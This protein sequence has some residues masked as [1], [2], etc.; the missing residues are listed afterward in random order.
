[1]YNDNRGMKIIIGL[2]V[3]AGILFGL[4]ELGI[5]GKSD[6]DKIRERMDKFVTAYNNG[7]YEGMLECIEPVKRK[8]YE[9]A[10][11]MLGSIGSGL[12]GFD[13]SVSDLMGLSAMVMTEEEKLS[14]EITRI[15]VLDGGRA[16]V[17]VRNSNGEET[18]SMVKD[19]RDWYFAS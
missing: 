8:Q 9:A 14:L 17:Y 13:F 15:S 16:L 4:W 2:L 6:E 11:N 7:D 18:F 5:I 3:V 1:M 10:Y 19:G 12:L